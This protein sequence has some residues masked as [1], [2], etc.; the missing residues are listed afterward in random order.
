LHFTRLRTRDQPEC[1][2]TGVW[3]DRQN[4]PALDHCRDSRV[5]A[6]IRGLNASL[7]PRTSFVD[8]PVFAENEGLTGRYCVPAD[9]GAGNANLTTISNFFQVAIG[10]P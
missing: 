5:F 3:V 6:S 10:V 2:S 4:E 1:V 7:P 9:K 8:E